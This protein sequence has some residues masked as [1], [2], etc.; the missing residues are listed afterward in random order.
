M[1]ASTTL[2]QFLLMVVAG[3]L[4]RQQAAT[5]DYLK[6]ENRMLRAR[7]GGRRIVFTDAERR[8]L[9]EKARALGRR[10]LH[11]LGT[12]VTPET[13]LRWHRELVARKWTFAERRSPGR[14]RIR[15]E[16]VALVVR[17]A[18]DNRGWGYTRIQGVI[19]N[20]GHE[21]GR[22]TIGRILKDHGIE[23]APERGKGMSWSVFLK[24]HWKVL[25]ASDFFTVE[26]WSWSG[27]VTYYVLFVMELATRRVCIAGITKHPDTPWMLQMARQLT[28]GIDGILLDKRYIILDRDTKYCQVFRDF[29]KRE[30][31]EVIRLPPRSPNLNAHAERWVR[32]VRDEC[33]SRLIPIGEG[34]LR[35]ALREYGTHF[36]QERNHQGLGNVL[37]MPDASN[38]HGGG[39]VIRRARLGGLLNFYERAAA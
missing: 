21:L 22:G 36:H 14:P 7:L 28:D 32:G 10:A 24:A 17:M 12:I 34:M 19:A 4:Q 18:T 20:L 6:A 11:E 37:I 30:G 5:I 1:A 2:L 27:L 35:R 39:P 16:L 13:L 38:N 26:V 25:A 15:Q 23:P 9:A 29:V 33:L 8:Q 3:W 31:V